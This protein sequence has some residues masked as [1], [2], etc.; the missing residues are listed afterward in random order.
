MNNE[1]AILENMLET[2]DFNRE[3]RMLL[4]DFHE[5]LE[6]ED[7]EFREEQFGDGE[8]AEEE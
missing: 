3:E 1:L 4:E 7:M 8:N 6:R 2:Y 5:L